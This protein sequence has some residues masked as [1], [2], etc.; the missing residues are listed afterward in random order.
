MPRRAPVESITQPMFGHSAS[1]CCSV[2]TVN[3]FSPE[4]FFSST[5]GSASISCTLR[6]IDRPSPL[7]APDVPL[8]DPREAVGA[9]R[10]PRA[11]RRARSRAAGG[12][13]LD[14]ERIR[15]RVVEKPVQP[16]LRPVAPS[17][18]RIRRRAA[19]GTPLTPSPAAS[20]RRCRVWQPAMAELQH[21]L[22]QLRR[23]RSHADVELQRSSSRSQRD[24]VDAVVEALLRRG[25]ASDTGRLRRRSSFSIARLHDTAAC[26]SGRAA[27]DTRASRSRPA[28]PST[29][30]PLRAPRLSRRLGRIEAPPA[31]SAPARSASGSWDR[32]P[33]GRATLCRSVLRVLEMPRRRSTPASRCGPARRRLAAAG[34]DRVRD[35]SGRP[36]PDRCG[37]IVGSLPSRQIG[38][39]ACNGLGA[40]R[41]STPM[42]SASRA[43]NVLPAK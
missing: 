19:P 25:T 31:R 35:L 1:I 24:D 15:L 38:D 36:R 42:A 43:R 10:P 21:L 7:R 16:Q 9:G 17:A 34:R 13:A 29:S 4:K 39:N 22:G 11:D 37:W 30:P 20:G 8:D 5:S 40:H 12:V 14:G 18:A 6:R 27:R 23:A 33:R 26:G 28:G 2:A 41:S 32:M 3:V